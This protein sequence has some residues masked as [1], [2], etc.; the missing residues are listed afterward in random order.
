MG[1]AMKL[2]M[3]LSL[4]LFMVL[5]V[6]ILA[7]ALV[8]Y[9]PQLLADILRS[10]NEAPGLVLLFVAPPLCVIFVYCLAGWQIDAGTTVR[11]SDVLD[12]LLI[13]KRGE[14]GRREK[15]FAGTSSKHAGRY[16]VVTD[17]SLT[18]L[19]SASTSPTEVLDRLV[20]FK[21][22]RLWLR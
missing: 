17:I 12:R 16:F 8:A 11:S 1:T 7:T 4:A 15:R 18:L 9:S 13:R 19:Q 21:R 2:R 6:A 20:E 3:H 10:V 22:R 5:V 14:L